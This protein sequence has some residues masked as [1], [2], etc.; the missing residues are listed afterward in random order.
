MDC[1][2]PVLQA[3]P[4]S[5]PAKTSR[6][7]SIQQVMA[8]M[9]AL[10][11]I[12]ALTLVLL[13]GGA[14]FRSVEQD[15]TVFQR[16]STPTGLYFVCAGGVKLLSRGPG[17]RTRV[18][19]LFE[20]GSMFGDI[21]VFTGSPYRTWTQV[22]APALLIH[23]SRSSVLAAVHRDNQL[24]TRMLATVAARTQRLIDGITATSPV[25]FD[26]SCRRLS[27]GTRRSTRRG[28]RTP[29]P[30]GVEKHRSLDAQPCARELFAR[31]APLDGCRDRERDGAFDPHP[32]PARPARTDQRSRLPRVDLTPR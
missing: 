29:A 26:R 14:E 23:V 4:R 3:P 25:P 31:P 9:P 2:E 32:R 12:E 27:D 28:G 7:A 10:R 5:R 24:A 30:A 20:P 11:G 19:E 22:T 17:N 16:G 1:I 15:A 18:I 8:G 21:G 13:A 6:A